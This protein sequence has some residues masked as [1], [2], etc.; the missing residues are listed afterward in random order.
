MNSSPEV[1]EIVELK[2]LVGKVVGNHDDGHAANYAESY[3]L[4]VVRSIILK[5]N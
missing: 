3:A 2:S 5:H 4:H 1:G